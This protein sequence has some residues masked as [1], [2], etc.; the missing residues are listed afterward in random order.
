[1]KVKPNRKARLGCEDGN[2]NR[3]TAQIIPYTDFP[4]NEIEIWV[5]GGVMLMPKEH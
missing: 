2:A 5:E 1:L 3:I 4:L